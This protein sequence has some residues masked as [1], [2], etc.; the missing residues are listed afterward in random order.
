MEF[1]PW[2]P[3]S[4]PVYTPAIRNRRI[5][6][7]R[8]TASPIGSNAR[9]MEQLAVDPPLER[10]PQYSRLPFSLRPFPPRTSLIPAARLSSSRSRRGPLARRAWHSGSEPLQ[11]ASLF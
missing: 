2:L 6:F 8:G 4:A 7:L 9:V 5:G 10:S 1:P 11:P 3:A